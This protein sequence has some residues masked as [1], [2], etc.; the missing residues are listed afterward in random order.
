MQFGTVV[1]ISDPSVNITFS[2]PFPTVCLNVQATLYDY[3]NS[4]TPYILT[5]SNISSSSFT[6]TFFNQSGLSQPIGVTWTA[7]GN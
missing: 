5:I 1:G 6:V 3:N 2:Q 4:G 7:Y